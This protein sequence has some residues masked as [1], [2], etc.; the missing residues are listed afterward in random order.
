MTILSGQRIVRVGR[1]DGRFLMQGEIDLHGLL[2]RMLY[3]QPFTGPIIR[4]ARLAITITLLCIHCKIV[5]R[6]GPRKIIVR[7]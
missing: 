6:L 2:G 5:L 3:E 4:V 7:F 1:L